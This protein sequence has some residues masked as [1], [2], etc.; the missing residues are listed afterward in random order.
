MQC[1]ADYGTSF[2]RLLWPQLIINMRGL[3][4]VGHSQMFIRDLLQYRAATAI[5][6]QRQTKL[7]QLD[8]FKKVHDIKKRMSFR[9]IY[10]IDD[11]IFTQDMPDYN[12]AKRELLD[13]GVY[14][15]E[16]MELCDEITVSTP[17]LRDYYLKNTN[18]KNISVLP[19]C[20]PLFWIGDHFN[21]DR[22]LR[23]YRTHIAKP[24]ILYAGSSSHFHLFQEGGEIPDDFTH[25]KEVIMANVDKFKWIF[26][27]A[28]PTALINLIKAGIVEYH[29][30]M[31]LDVY[32]SFLANLQ[33]N[34]CIA[35]LQENDFN[36]A[37]SDLKFLEA[38]ALGLPIACQDMCTYSIAPIKF[39]T[40]EE[41]IKRINE[42]L[43]SEETFLAA[44]RRA[45]TLLE[46]RWLEREENIGKY[47]DVYCYPLGHPMRKYV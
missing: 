6:I 46:G 1:P 27:G 23:N 45:R 14:A 40:G 25:V 10:D 8:F 21:E 38:A 20:P 29:P 7:S 35:P 44:S 41:M 16:I 19:N 42:T 33:V 47:L 36:R 24:R 4:R 34:M 2:W 3:A 18:Q 31:R 22:I 43:E 26:V 11:V 28:F 12:L 37:K 30:W 5:H 9:L 39:R 13:Q 32:P 17:F 15:K